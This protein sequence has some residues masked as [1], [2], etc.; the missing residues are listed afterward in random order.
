LYY[1][2]CKKIKV[3]NVVLIIFLQSLYKV[4]IDIVSKKIITN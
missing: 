2:Y 1:W 3:K 4:I